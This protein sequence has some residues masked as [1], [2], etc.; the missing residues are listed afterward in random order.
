V[1]VVVR[2]DDAPLRAALAD[3]QV[4]FVA[5]PDP[6]GDMLSSVRC[7]LLALP[8]DCTVALVA[9]GDQP[10]LS[11]ALVRELIAAYRTADRSILVPTHAGRRGHP[12]L[13]STRFRH[14]ILSHFE[15]VGLR[16]LLLAHPDELLEWPTADVA[17][18]EDLDRP[19]DYRRARRG[20]EETEGTART[21]APL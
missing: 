13:F 20:R 10:G 1:L 17:V 2:P 5:N 4:A 12:L 8:A 6:A 9:T 18:L 14:E 16:G 19:D 3:R 7:G 21:H 11:A 15:G